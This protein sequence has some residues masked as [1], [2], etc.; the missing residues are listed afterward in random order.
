M[1]ITSDNE[2]SSV[3]HLYSFFQPASL[4]REFYIKTRKGP[5]PPIYRQ[6]QNG[7][8]V[9]S[10]SVATYITVSA[11]DPAVVTSLPSHVGYAFK[12]PNT[13]SLAEP[14]NVSVSTGFV[15]MFPLQ[16]GFNTV[17]KFNVFFKLEI[18]TL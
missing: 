7:I 5:S 16:H 2:S 8:L 9:P 1:A 17:L 12:I 6:R 10:S 3:P 14:C 11:A 4:L 15:C 18:L 13:N